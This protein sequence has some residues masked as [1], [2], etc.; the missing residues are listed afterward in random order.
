MMK[1]NK[2]PQ[3]SKRHPEK[4][5]QIV[6]LGNRTIAIDRL[7]GEQEIIETRELSKDKTE[8]PASWRYQERSKS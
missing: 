1:I 7:T 3:T 8:F 2:T 4:W 6:R 5:F